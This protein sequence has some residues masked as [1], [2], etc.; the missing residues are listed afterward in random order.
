MELV[1]SSTVVLLIWFFF[2]CRGHFEYWKRKGIA[3]Y[4]PSMILT[5]LF[6]QIRG[7]VDIGTIFSRWY[8]HHKGKGL[9]FFGS[10]NLLQPT[11]VVI[12]LDLCKHI[13]SKDFNH[14]VSREMGLLTHEY[15]SKHLF[16]LEG[17][18]WKDMRTMLTPTF[19]SGKMKRMFVLMKKCVEQLQEHVEEAVLREG[20]FDVKDLCS[21]HTSDIIA[22]C[23]FGLDLNCIRDG[24]SEFTRVG[25]LLIY[26]SSLLAAICNYLFLKYF[27]NLARVLDVRSV[28]PQYTDMFT[29]LVKDTVEFR[30]KND[31]NRNDFIDLMMR[32]NE[33]KCSEG[34]VQAANGESDDADR[35]KSKN[36]ES[37]HR[38]KDRKLKLFNDDFKISYLILLTFGENKVKI[39][40]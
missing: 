38:G 10:W 31:V 6:D 29:K 21:R 39:H 7:R 11:L 40:V 15:I 16:A 35:L 1:I 20:E 37:V 4:G 14:F 36:K 19:T 12:D 33:G 8:S 17:Q 18:E 24:E 32:V 5:A 28:D 26:P 34:D 13:L 23:A 22:S 9:R 2:Y 3:H 25:K 27:P 30:T